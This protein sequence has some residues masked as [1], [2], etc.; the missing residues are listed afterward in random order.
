MFSLRF[1]VATTENK[2]EINNQST[3]RLAFVEDL[4]KMEICYTKPLFTLI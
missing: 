4:V 2:I 3:W 1:W